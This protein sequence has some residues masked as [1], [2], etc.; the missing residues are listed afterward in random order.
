MAQKKEQKEQASKRIALLVR[1]M[2]NGYSVDL[3]RE[4]YMYNDVQSLLEGLFVH[5]G[6]NRIGAMTKEEI[7]TMVEELPVMERDVIY[8]RFNFNCDTKTK[9][10]RQVGDQ[11]GVSAETVRQMEIRAIRKLRTNFKNKKAYRQA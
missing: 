6:M 1:T 10:L 3:E 11:L 9:T 4:G 5:V 8:S 2:V 7:K